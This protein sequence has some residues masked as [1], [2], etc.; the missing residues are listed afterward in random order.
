M[1]TSTDDMTDE[2]WRSKSS[3]WHKGWRYGQGDV[4]VCRLDSADFI[5]G[6]RY[7]LE[8]PFGHVSVPM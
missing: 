2:E 3:D 1:I 8:R 4:S 5:A 6:Y 7:A